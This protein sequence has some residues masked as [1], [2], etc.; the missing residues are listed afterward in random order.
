VHLII[1]P[2]LPA[3]DMS[4]IRRAI[5]Q[6][7]SRLA[8]SWLRDNSPDWIA[9]LTRKR[10]RRTETH[11]WQSGG[12]YDRNVERGGSLLKMIG[13][14]HLNP[15]RR[16]LVDRA[17]EWNWSSAGQFQGMGNSLLLVDPVPAHCL[18]QDFWG[19]APGTRRDD[20]H[21]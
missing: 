20:K 14:I 1:L 15:V 8:L 18:D 10:G 19:V 17:E 11:F 7:T 6:P 9:R 12:G 13:Y 4:R 2:R 21:D 3:Y 5:K 16:G